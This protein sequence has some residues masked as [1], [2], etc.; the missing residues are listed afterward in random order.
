MDASKD[1][2]K[3]VA[4]FRDILEY[5]GLHVFEN[6]Y[7][8]VDISPLKHSEGSVNPE[9]MMLGLLPDSQRYFDYHHA[10]TDVIEAVNPRELHLGAGAMAALVY[11]IDKHF[12]FN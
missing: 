4:L 10:D 2:V 3:R 6:G 12:Q 7:S 8:G 1:E 9:I 11:L 5:Y